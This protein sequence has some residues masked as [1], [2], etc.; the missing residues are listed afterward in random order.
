MGGLRTLLFL[1]SSY[2][3]TTYHFSFKFGPFIAE[4]ASPVPA[5]A[6]RDPPNARYA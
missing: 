6:Y 2:V 4:F 5:L 1:P 3:S